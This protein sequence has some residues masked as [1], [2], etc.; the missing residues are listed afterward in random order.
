M[1]QQLISDSQIIVKI[2]EKYEKFIFE[3]ELKINERS[4]SLMRGSGL[5]DYDAF[6]LRCCSLHRARWWELKH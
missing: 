6:L 2:L 3:G 5:D 1:A 4:W